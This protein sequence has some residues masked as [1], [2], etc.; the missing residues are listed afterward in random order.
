MAVV[1][2]R[3]SWLA[4]LLPSLSPNL[5][6]FP[7]CGA[8]RSGAPLIRDRSGLRACYDPGS[9]A[10][11]FAALRA[12]PRPGN[13]SRRD[14]LP[15]RLPD[16]VGRARLRA[17]EKKKTVRLPRISFHSIRA[18]LAQVSPVGTIAAVS[19]IIMMLFS[20]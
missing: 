4:H 5:A 9:A 6:A 17:P 12:A 1:L 7:G 3:C 8:A 20:G 18:T 16:Q 11:H 15:S 10:H 2:L 14:W 19:T 13:E